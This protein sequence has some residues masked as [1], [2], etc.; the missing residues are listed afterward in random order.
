MR[1]KRKNNVTYQITWEFHEI[2]IGIFI[3][4]VKKIFFMYNKWRINS[5]KRRSWNRKKIVLDIMNNYQRLLGYVI[6]S[7]L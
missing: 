6:Y 3:F 5:T 7:K 4:T 1:D 2:C